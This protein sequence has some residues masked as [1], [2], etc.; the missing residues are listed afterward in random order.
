MVDFPNG[1]SENFIY[2]PD[3]KL[4]TLTDVGVDGITSRTW[5]YTWLGDDLERLDRPDGIAWRFEYT[6]P[7][8][9]GF[10]TRMVLEGT[11]ASER[12]LGAW[13]Y[14]ALGNVVR[15]WRG[16]AAFEDVAAVQKWSFTFDDPQL[17]TE[18][19][20]TDPLGNT[21]TYFFGK[22]LAS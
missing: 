1:R 12:I 19:V 2:D 17:P 10:M 3:S 16:A 6:D 13:E 21:M 4:A 20:I 14:D 8:H 11:D 7:A 5:S 22:D 18:T 9:P 15:I